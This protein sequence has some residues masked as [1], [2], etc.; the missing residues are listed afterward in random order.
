MRFAAL[1]LALVCCLWG[2]RA[3][4]LG[5]NAAPGDGKLVM[6]VVK[7]AP[8]PTLLKKP[9][10]ASSLKPARTELSQRLPRTRVQPRRAAPAVVRPVT[11]TRRSEQP[12]PQLPSALGSLRLQLELDAMREHSH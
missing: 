12:R 8:A 1:V 2:G 10:R 5:G 4:A 7:P 6:V 9:A 3:L 11:R